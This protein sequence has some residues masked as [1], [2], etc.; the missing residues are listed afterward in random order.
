MQC[1]DGQTHTGNQLINQSINQSISIRYSM[2]T[3]W[4]TCIVFSQVLIPL[5]ATL[6][7][8]DP[9]GHVLF[10]IRSVTGNVTTNIGV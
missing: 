8:T 4:Q 7:H 3:R 10:R 5:Y 6:P 1:N 2:A 9:T